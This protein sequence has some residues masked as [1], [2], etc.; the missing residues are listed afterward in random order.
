V[1]RLLDVVL[2]EVAAAP[3]R[4]DAYVERCLYDPEAGFYTAGG[5][6]G[7]RGDFLTSAEVGPLF[8]AVLARAV[9]A[10]WD[11]AGRPSPFV[12]V[13][14]GTGS[15]TLVRALL[16]AAPA[17]AAAWQLV[18]VERSPVLRAA[19]RDLVQRGVRS[20]P[21]LPGDLT[22]AVVIANE[23]LDNLPFR[24]LERRPDGWADLAVTS[25]DG[26][27][28]LTHLAADH[29]AARVAQGLVGDVPTGTRIPLLTEAA[30]WVSGVV[31][32]AAHLV[33]FDYGAPST[34]ALARRPW[35][36]WVRTYRAHQRAGSPLDDPGG[37]DVTVEVAADQLPPGA[38]W[39]DQ[40]AFLR[41]WGL[42]QLVAEGR[43][44]WTE[45]AARP[46]LEA[47]R[48]RSRVREAEALTDPDGLGSFLVG[49]WARTA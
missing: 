20:T 3:M 35:T 32:T 33:V 15:G 8:G 16:H 9:D 19:H 22:G 36:S 44:C 40:A 18:A 41:S 37:A 17:C 24:V 12:V 27:L 43:R 2:A 7:R 46:D 29:H 39:S 47:L 28:G 38:R 14:A 1:G 49:H 21:T 25:H 48:G 23:L 26:R 5:A 30:R 10:W 4:F 11:E 34:A 13:D 42:D 45:R 6:A 31:A